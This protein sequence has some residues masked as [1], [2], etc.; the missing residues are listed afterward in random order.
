MTW[1]LKCKAFTVEGASLTAV[2]AAWAQ[3]RHGVQDFA[4]AEI[5]S[6]ED[7][8][9][10]GGATPPPELP[11]RPI[12]APVALL[13]ES[14]EGLFDPIPLGWFLYALMDARTAIRY[15]GDRH[16]HLHWRCDLQWVDGGGRLCGGVGPTPAQAVAD[17]VRVVKRLWGPSP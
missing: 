16:E 12:A 5:L 9:V 11:E 1:I 8:W 7:K 15:R 10:P 14:P 3:R 17:A 2:A 13:V 4:D 6:I